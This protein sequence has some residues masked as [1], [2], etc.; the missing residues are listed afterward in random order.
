MAF[1]SRGSGNKTAP[2]KPA[3]ASS[4]PPIA[5]AMQAAPQAAAAL[6]AKAAAPPAAVEQKPRPNAV[7]INGQ[8]TPALG[9]IIAVLMTSPP[10]RA[11]TLE[12]ILTQVMPCIGANQ[13]LVADAKMGGTDDKKEVTSPVALVLWANVSEAVDKRLSADPAKPTVIA[14]KEWKSGSIPWVIEAVGPP[15]LVEAML[16]QLVSGPLK[17]QSLKFRRRNK[18]G[19]FAIESWPAKK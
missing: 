19:A 8:V 9:K 15:Q 18:D 7:G 6:P 2:E 11:M 17:G 3:P 5:K 13:F 1:W 16:K 14:P 12:T 4:P 10:H